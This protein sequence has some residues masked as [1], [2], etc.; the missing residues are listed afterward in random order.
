[1]Q[2][3]LKLI[4]TFHQLKLKQVN[5]NKRNERFFFRLHKCIKNEEYF[6]EYPDFLD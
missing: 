1:M 2:V 5:V 6:I 4:I 3:S